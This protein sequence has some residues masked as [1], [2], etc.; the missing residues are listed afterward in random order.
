METTTTLETTPCRVDTIPP[1]EN[2]VKTLDTASK[3]KN[4]VVEGSERT[5][6]PSI[7]E[8]ADDKV[9]E[10]HQSVPVMFIEPDAGTPAAEALAANRALKVSM[11]TKGLRKLQAQK[12]K[13]KVKKLNIVKQLRK[14]TYGIQFSKNFKGK[15]IDGVHELYTLTA[16]MMLGMR[17]SVGRN[18]PSF[19]LEDKQLTLEDFSHVEK[20]TFPAAGSPTTPPHSLVHTFKFKSYSLKVFR[21]VRDFFGKI[22]PCTPSDTLVLNH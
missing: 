18:H 14:T 1:K 11:V 3:L 22:F 10:Q 7:A 20:I 5:G 17:C 9:G 4:V 2:W 15:V 19:Q 12:L 16:G 8:S 13:R 21:R 6:P